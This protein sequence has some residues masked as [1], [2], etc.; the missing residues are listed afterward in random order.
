MRGIAETNH[1]F[2]TWSAAMA[3]VNELYDQADQL[4]VDGKLE[5]AVAKYGEILTADPNY[6]L[7][8]AALAVVYGRL[9]KHDLAIEH[10][11]KVC[12]IAPQDPFSHT[13]LSVIYQR[14][15]AGTNNMQFIQD[16]E[17]AM[18]RSQ[19]LQQGNA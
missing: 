14:A 13:Q 5:E 12:E 6:A 10:A 4:K 7:A 15:Y 9:G 18:A 17:E 19:M 16:A 2:K 1:A 8:H 3:D 11:R